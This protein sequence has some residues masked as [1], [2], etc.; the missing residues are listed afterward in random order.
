M[1]GVPLGC[2]MQWL[3]FEGHSRLSPFLPNLLVFDAGLSFLDCKVKT[4]TTFLM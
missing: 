1:I 2:V 3:Q 4:R